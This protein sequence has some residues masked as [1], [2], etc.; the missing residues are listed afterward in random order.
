[1][2]LSKEMQNLQELIA[3]PGW[4]IFS[5]LVLTKLRVQINDKL[6]ASAR[7]GETT[8]SAKFAGQIDILPVIIA[9]PEQE[10]EKAMKK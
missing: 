7:A 6:M 10:L 8:D 9:L 2:P 1:M 4:E 3:H 5:N